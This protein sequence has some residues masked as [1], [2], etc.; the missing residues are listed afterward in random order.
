MCD[1]GPLMTSVSLNYLI[2]SEQKNL[3]HKRNHYDNDIVITVIPF[4]S[5]F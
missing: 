4:Y 1:F 5:Y 2:Y 3:F